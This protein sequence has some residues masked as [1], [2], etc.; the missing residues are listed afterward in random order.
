MGSLSGG[1]MPPKAFGVPII[2]IDWHLKLMECQLDM[3]ISYVS[4]FFM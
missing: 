4:E 2:Y 1:K 3:I